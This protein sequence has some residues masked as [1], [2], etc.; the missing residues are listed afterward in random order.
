MDAP[1]DPSTSADLPPTGARRAVLDRDPPVEQLPA[2]RVGRGEVT[3][4]ARLGP[5]GDALGDPLLE[6]RVVELEAGHNVEDAVDQGERA[7]CLVDG[8]AV[9]SPAIELG[10]GASDERAEGAK[11]FRRVQDVEQRSHRLTLRD[12]GGLAERRRS[13]MSNPQ[14]LGEGAEAGERVAR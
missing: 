12:P 9:T 11:G 6:R 3:T 2:N 13:A 8:L 7:A 4:A 10:V 14:P 1:F 5:R